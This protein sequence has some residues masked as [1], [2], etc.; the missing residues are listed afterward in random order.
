MINLTNINYTWQT[1]DK[2][3]EILPACMDWCK[4]QHYNIAVY[5]LKTALFVV[6]FCIGLMYIFHE[7]DPFQYF[8]I[9]DKYKNIFCSNFV[10]TM[11]FYIA[12]IVMAYVSFFMLK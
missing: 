3:P 5:D 8:E 6:T 10:I 7:Y 1:A 4:E 2:T 9:E 12:L 11:A